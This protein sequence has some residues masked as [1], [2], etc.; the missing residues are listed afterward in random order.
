MVTHPQNRSILNQNGYALVL[1]LLVLVLLSSLGLAAV[2]QS[3][4]ET[5]VVG[6]E[7]TG[8][9]LLM[10][11]DAGAEYGKNAIWSQ[12][13]FGHNTAVSF[14]NLDAYFN[15]QQLPIVMPAATLTGTSMYQVTIP[16]QVTLPDGTLVSG[17]DTGDG[18][19]RVVTFQSRSWEDADGNGAFNAGEKSRIITSRVSYEYGSLSFPYGM[20]TQNTECILCHANIVGDVVSLNSLTV[21][22]A[23]E[24]YSRILG[25]V[26]TL[27]IT[28]LNDP[29]NR[30]VTSYTD[31][32]GDY[33]TTEAI[34]EVPLNITT[35]YSD[36]GR[37]PVDAN[38][39]P[40]F[41]KI[42]NLTYYEGLALAHNNGA[43]SF[44]TGG[45]KQSV[46]VGA[47]YNGGA[48]ATNVATVA[49]SITANL[50]LTGTPGNCL[51]LDGPV[52]VKGDVIISG[53]VQ[54]AGSIYT[55]GNIYV[56]D[57]LTYL[58]PATDKLGLAAGGN[59]VIGDYRDTSAAKNKANQKAGGGKYIKKELI[60]FNTVVKA[61]YPAG[62][63]RYYAA[64]DGLV[65]L[66]K[67][68]TIT[69]AAT[70]TVVS[71][72]PTQTGGVPW[73]TD[74]EYLTNYVD[75][76]NGVT[77]LDALSYTANGI[78]GIQRRPPRQMTINGALVSAD[79]GILIPGGC[80]A[81]C[82]KAPNYDPA[83]IGLT[84]NYDNRMENFLSVARNPAK[85]T[86]SWREGT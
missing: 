45:T 70:D 71:Y 66:S 7:R 46:A 82:S 47:T 75:Q 41:P 11:A 76:V 78:F 60:S 77:Q 18:S 48:G 51:Q 81:G 24:A 10:A 32:N 74:T 15:G 31:Q 85:R 8:N 40:S 20:L 27:G 55:K 83:N 54:G 38:G 19:K 68:S 6:N 53:C 58:T 65:Y 44:I 21:R 56:P 42:N 80:A 59:I 43:G 12:S 69:P 39:K 2:F 50:I 16:A 52:V 36:P 14:Q 30:V 67:S 64:P 72:V 17:Y 22:K 34:G 25:K 79:I 61:T 86:V 73:I 35:N 37:F 57:S 49:H 9:A 5:T 62:Q 63:R 33:T 3:N 26:Y 29:A 84:L 23:N 1:S 13:G 4:T 28:N